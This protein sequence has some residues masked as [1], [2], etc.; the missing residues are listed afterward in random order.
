MFN[1]SNI[2]NT[3]QKKTKTP[4]FPKNEKIL[5]QK[6]RIEGSCDWWSV[7]SFPKPKW[8]GAEGVA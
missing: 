5:A 8:L 7:L 6:N 2:P 1:I 3:K 4:K